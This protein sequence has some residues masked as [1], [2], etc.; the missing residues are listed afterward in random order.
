[1]SSDFGGLRK[2]CECSPMFLSRG[3]GTPSDEIFLERV[4]VCL[5]L[6]TLLGDPVEPS[7]ACFLVSAKH[8]DRGGYGA[9][10]G[11]LAGD[12]PSTFLLTKQWT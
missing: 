7:C 12:Y 3:R 5:L 1:M 6:C 4:K 11:Y 9:S 10:R 8:L 2:G